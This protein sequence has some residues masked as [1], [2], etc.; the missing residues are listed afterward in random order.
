[1]IVLNPH[2]FE[3]HYKLDCPYCDRVNKYLV[4]PLEAM[5]VINVIHINTVAI[6][7]TASYSNNIRYE[8]EIRG[9]GTIGTPSL[10]DLSCKTELNFLPV[11][12]ESKRPSVKGSIKDMTASLIDHLCRHVII[13]DEM[14]VKRSLNPIDIFRSK[15]GVL[16]KMALE[17]S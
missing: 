17:G 8:S 14:G 12:K 16:V 4:L 3:F 6:R 10:I 7:G 5:G 9:E 15:F 1:M 13:E 11:E 2:K